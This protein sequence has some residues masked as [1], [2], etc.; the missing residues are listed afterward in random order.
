M[1]SRSQSRGVKARHLHLG[2]FQGERKRTHLAVGSDFHSPPDRFD[3]TL[4][5]RPGPTDQNAVAPL[6]W[7]LQLE[8]LGGARKRDFAPKPFVA[9]DLTA[10]I[11]PDS[12][13]R[14][15]GPRHLF[16]HRASRSS[17]I[18]FVSAV[19]LGSKTPPLRALSAIRRTA[20][21]LWGFF[22]RSS[23]E[24]ISSLSGVMRGSR[25]TKVP[26]PWI[27]SRRGAGTRSLGTSGARAVASVVSE[28]KL[29]D[30]LPV[31]V[32]GERPTGLVRLAVTAIVLM[33]GEQVAVFVVGVGDTF[34]VVC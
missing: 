18:L 21:R 32:V 6:P 12:Q 14:H 1:L 16:P 20:F 34:F 5:Q 3:R 24:R 4:G 27:G 25:A 13:A 29:G 28:G 11:L 15:R 7:P 9:K 33:Y 30:Q 22:I 23:K 17:R 31:A 26:M 2:A 19:F 10:G 8:G